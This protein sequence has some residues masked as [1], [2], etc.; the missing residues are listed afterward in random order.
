MEELEHKIIV[1]QEQYQRLEVSYMG[2]SRQPT[3]TC[4]EKNGTVNVAPGEQYVCWPWGLEENGV[5]RTM[6]E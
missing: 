3:C 2:L 6:E 4:T 1:L 5:R